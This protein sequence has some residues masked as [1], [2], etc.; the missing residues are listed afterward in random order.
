MDEEEQ[1]NRGIAQ[2]TARWEQTTLDKFL[3]KGGE[4]KDSFFTKSGIAVKQLYTPAD[5]TG[6]YMNSLGFP[7]EFPFTRGVYPTMY[8]G[9]LW[10]MRQYAG[11]ASARLTNER[12][13]YLLAQGQ[14]GLSVAFDLPT[15]HGYDADDPHAEGEVGRVGVT[16]N[17]L[18][19]ME[20]LFEGIP[21][22]QVSVSFTINSPAAILLAMFI[23]VARKQNVS[24]DQLRGTVQNDILKEYVARGTYIFPPHAGMRL[25]T[26]I[27]EYC[28]RELPNFNAISISGYHMREA[29]C[30][31]VQE[32]AFTLADGI[33]YVNAVLARGLDVDAFAA[34]L[35]FFFCAQNNLFEEVA[36]F[37]A[38]RRLWAKIM[39]D[40]FGAQSPASQML[41]FHAQTAGVAL[42]AQQPN[43]NIV[44]VAYQALAAVLGGA[45]SLHTNS[46][47][48]A[49][50]IPTEESV[51]LALRTQQILAEET[52]VPDAVDPLGG[53]Y[54]IETLTDQ[55]EGG[56]RE[57]LAKVEDLGGMV[58]AIEGGYVQ[59]EILEAAYRAQLEIDSGH[60]VV[61]GVNK[62]ADHAGEKLPAFCIDGGSLQETLDLLAQV[63]VDR[64]Q[65]AVEAALA[66]VQAA[67]Q[68][69]ENVL[70]SIIAAVE[71]YATIGEICSVL[72]NTFGEFASKNYL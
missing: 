54:Y 44:R 63:R 27:L 40:Q 33:A 13:K 28:A 39:R 47:D 55:I 50:C 37:R 59:R 52:G 31:A 57:Y 67:A 61:V 1:N 14:K 41:R 8:R 53:S 38:A 5:L 51:T 11:F 21:L 69:E 24:L 58:A 66:G 17:S 12:F 16:I 64:D 29:G 4:R 56:A 9:Q 23:A 3:S 62:F 45:Q 15:Q 48:E 34:R 30:T 26:D 49:L 43:S 25:C 36:K 10:T 20:L 2:E 35:S 65:L 18:A 71:A 7:G 60:Q 6:T 32:V 72:R 70:P 22:D 68:G 19:D 46:R 42:T